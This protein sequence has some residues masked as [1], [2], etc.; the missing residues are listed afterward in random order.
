MKSL[1]RFLADEGAVAA[2]EYCL[3][4]AVVGVAII[5]ASV[6]LGDAIT[7]TMAEVSGCMSKGAN[8]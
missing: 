7:G 1:R 2:A 4:L 3:I 5:T 8:C 6:G